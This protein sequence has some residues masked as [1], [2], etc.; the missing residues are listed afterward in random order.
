M[1]FHNT[2]TQMKQE[3]TPIIDGKVSMYVC[4]PTVYDR[5]HIGNA[6][7][8]VVYDTLYRLLN[9]IYGSGN[10]T[11]VRNITDVDDKINARAIEL[12]ISIQELTSKTY[13]EFQEDMSYLNCLS[14]TYEPKATEHIKDIISINEKLIANNHAYVSEGHV[15]FDVTSA[16]GYGC[17]SGRNLD[18]MISGA[19]VEVSENKRHPGD[20]VLW[21][22]ASSRDDASS[23]FES[24]WGP[25]RPGWHI[26]CSVMSMYFLGTDFDIHGGGAD[27]IFPHHT[28]E[29]AQSSCAFP[30]STFARYWVHNGFLTVNGEKMSKSLGN[31]M[32]VHDL[33]EKGVKGEVIRYLLLSTHYRKPLDFNDKAIYDS[34]ESLDY[35]YRA[36]ENIQH[37]E[38][39]GD[40]SAFLS[41]LEDDINTAGALSFMHDLAKQIN[42]ASEKAQLVS[43][44][45][46]C[47]NLI[48]LLFEE[49]WFHSEDGVATSYVEELILKRIDAKKSRQFEA[50]DAIRSE[51][52]SLGIEVE[53]RPDGTSIWRKK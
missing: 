12:G 22:P 35:L 42:K 34:K 19:R 32:T 20:F 7:S 41:Y 38:W 36:M 4:G 30:G 16:K 37:E 13:V 8:V 51:L 29:I 1:K 18:E 10:I 33:A 5:P 43:Q 49:N 28:N 52:I 9:H 26:E 2:L 45:K 3:F 50:A 44:L 31:F 47:G 27:L 48:G 11:Y 40:N 17:L 39:R 23:V 24:P 25:G 21:K 14:P 6:R 15:Y 46:A 53:D